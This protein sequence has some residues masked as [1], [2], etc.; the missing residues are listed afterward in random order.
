MIDEKTL[1]AL[2][3]SQKEPRMQARRLSV[4]TEEG[5]MVLLANADAYGYE[6]DGDG[7]IMSVDGKPLDEKHED[8]KSIMMRAERQA[9]VESPIGA[10]ILKEAE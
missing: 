9:Q 4:R 8:Y 5:R 10:D 3:K 6:V 2:A 1:K 7:V